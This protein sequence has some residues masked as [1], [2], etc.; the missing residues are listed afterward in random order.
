METSKEIILNEFRR[1]QHG[2]ML[3][4]V[5]GLPFA[6]ELTSFY[7]PFN[8]QQG[9]LAQNLIVYW[10][11]FAISGNPNYPNS[12]KNIIQNEIRIWRIQLRTLIQLWLCEKT[13]IFPQHNAFMNHD[14]PELF[15]G[16]V[17]P[18]S[19][20][21]GYQVNRNYLESII[22]TTGAPSTT[23]LPVQLHLGNSNGFS[24]GDETIL[25][26]EPS[27]RSSQSPR[28][29]YDYCHGM[30][31]KETSCETE[32]V[33]YKMMV[34]IEMEVESLPQQHHTEEKGEIN[35]ATLGRRTINRSNCRLHS[36]IVQE[37]V[38]K[39]RSGNGGGTSILLPPPQICHVPN[40]SNISKPSSLKHNT[41][42]PKLTTFCPDTTILG[43]PSELSNLVSPPNNKP[44]DTTQ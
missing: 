36:S 40:T 44:I 19:Y 32:L 3:P 12:I 41:S 11:N 25:R 21:H 10:S 34:A 15:I 26:L 31:R 8:S 2:S 22:S 17:R 23:C 30:G 5:L 14:N 18:S 33:D 43:P 27:L 29:V 39:V 6:P 13:N 7:S 20:S 28:H 9:V 37:G 35:S 16:V 38:P 24:D 42:K 1:S 4:I